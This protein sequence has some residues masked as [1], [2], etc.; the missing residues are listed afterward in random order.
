[1]MLDT[2]LC[3]FGET[4]ALWHANICAIMRRRGFV[5]VSYDPRVFNKQDPNGAQI[6][7]LMHADNLFIRSKII[8]NPA[9]FEKCIANTCKEMKINTGHVVDYIGMVLDY[10][11]TALYFLSAWRGLTRGGTTCASTFFDTRD[12][13]KVTDEEVTF[14]RVLVAKLIYLVKRVRPGGLVVVAFLTTWARDVDSDDMGKLMSLL[15]YLRATQN[16]G[17]VLR[18]RDYMIVFAFI[19]VFFDAPI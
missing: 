2:A 18:V 17:I 19:D 6:E 1:M 11:T 5:S 14:F 3:S 16:C 10:I 8:Y 15:G 12:A 4:A 13:P 9:R 7:V